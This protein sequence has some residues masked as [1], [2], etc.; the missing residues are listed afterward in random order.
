MP[1]YDL[2][3]HSTYSDGVLS[4]GEII[5][6]A[7]LNNLTGIAITDHDTVAAFKD[8]AFSKENEL[9]II[10][11]IELS[12]IYNKAE[13]HILGYFLDY[14]N[15]ELNKT[16]DEIKLFRLTRGEKMVHRLNEM[17]YNISIEDVMEEVKENAS[18]GRPHI[19]RCLVKKGYFKDTYAV[20]EKLLGNGKPACIDRFKLHPKDGIELIKKSGGIPIL[21]HPYVCKTGLSNESVTT[22][23][24][25]MI[26][27]GIEGI[28][29]YHTLHSKVQE[30]ILLNI[31]IK[32]N[33]VVTGGSDCHESTD[34]KGQFI[35]GTK[36]IS[37]VDFKKLN[38]RR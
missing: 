29:V 21:A 33:L 23:I 28:E 32:N 10:P 26:S 6:I 12:T 8:P 34:D 22:M 11:G 17:N 38:L 9:N 15:I 24:K 14:D 30:G 37:L 20:F 27:W 13:I 7:K 25:D 3:I 2:H 19:A 4:V 31:A 36:G 16:L 18:F 1:N 5:N 35:I